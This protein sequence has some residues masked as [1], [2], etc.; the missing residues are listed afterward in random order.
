MVSALSAEDEPCAPLEDA[1]PP[2]GAA[3]DCGAQATRPPPAT[4]AAVAPRPIRNERRVK[5]EGDA[6]TASETSEA[7]ASIE[8]CSCSFIDPPLKGCRFRTERQAAVP[9]RPAALSATLKPRGAIARGAPGMRLPGPL[10]RMRLPV[11]L[12][13]IPSANHDCSFWRMLPAPKRRVLQ[14][15]RRTGAALQ[16]GGGCDCA[17]A[18]APPPKAGRR[19]RSDAWFGTQLWMREVFA[20]RFVRG[21]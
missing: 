16:S 8:W 19:Y 18:S 5:P 17:T 11:R 2:L 12:P 6:A 10:G 21:S 4:T 1:S 15:P 14:K 3:L 20:P 13:H 7:S 9:P